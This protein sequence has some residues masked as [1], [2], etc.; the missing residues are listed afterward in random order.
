MHVGRVSQPGELY[1]V[2]LVTE[3]RESWLG[4]ANARGAFL[5]VLRRWNEAEPGGVVATVVMPDHAHVLFQLGKRTGVGRTI[6]RWKSESRRASGYAGSFQRDF[7]E[8]RLRVGESVEDCALYIFLNPYRA[9]L[10]AADQAWA[11]WWS[12]NHALFRFTVLLGKGGAP[13]Q[14]WIGW[15]PEKFADLA[16]GE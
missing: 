6:A 4:A 16:H 2:T 14:E 1:F 10:L 9:G 7:W 12:P 5:D 15:P 3:R 11:G 13:P 8:H